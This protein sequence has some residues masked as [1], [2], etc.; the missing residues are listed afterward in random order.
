MRNKYHFSEEELLSEQEKTHSTSKFLSNKEV[1]ESSEIVGKAENSDLKMETKKNLT[2]LFSEKMSNPSKMTL[3][4]LNPNNLLGKRNSEQFNIINDR[5][6]NAP[7]MFPQ[8]QFLQLI[9]V[10]YPVVNY[11]ML[12]NQLLTE[13]SLTVYYNDVH[14]LKFFILNLIQ[15]YRAHNNLV[16]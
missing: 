3:K 12:I 16:N 13:L 14:S 8:Q 15:R 10:R 7:N 1:G 4:K 6:Q 5:S 2:N 11:Q 9:P